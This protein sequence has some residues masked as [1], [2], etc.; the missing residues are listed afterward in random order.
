M[1]AKADHAVATFEALK[2][3]DSAPAAPTPVASAPVASAPTVVSA[4]S[5]SGA[6]KQE[7][8]EAEKTAQLLLWAAKTAA[9]KGLPQAVTLQANAD[10][11]VTALEALKAGD[12]APA[13][14]A[15]VAS[16]PAAS[17]SAAVS[18]AATSGASHKEIS[19]AQQKADLLA[20]A[21]KTAAEKGLANALLMLSKA[22]EAAAV[23]E[24]MRSGSSA[25]SAPAASAPVASA[26]ASTPYTVE[27]LATAKNELDLFMWAAKTAAEKG[28]QQAAALKAKAESSLAAYKQMEMAL[29]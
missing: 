25:P 10:Y 23:V 4:A 21:A 2:A 18:V 13:T 1:Q 27:Q 26:P 22:D 19:E 29:A 17:A 9:A 16:A 11:A 3:G 14:P 15:A 6:S 8:A 12:S 28:L 20:W 5:T 24:A 7:I